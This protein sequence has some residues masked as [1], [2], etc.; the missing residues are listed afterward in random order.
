MP[1]I[2]AVALVLKLA[3]AEGAAPPQMAVDADGS[4]AVAHT[5]T[6]ARGSQETCEAS[7][8]S[9]PRERCN[10]PRI[11]QM[12]ERQFKLEFKDQKPFI[13]SAAENAVFKEQTSRENMERNSLD[14]RPQS[15]PNSTRASLPECRLLCAQACFAMRVAHLHALT[16]FAARVAHP[17]LYVFR[18]LYVRCS[19]AQFWDHGSSYTAGMGALEVGAY[20]RD[21]QPQLANK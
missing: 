7:A 10:I 17:P 15:R 13:M 19:F 9:P 4:A 12:T 14:V 20:V 6:A 2:V 8:A 1:L 21:L 16:C 11:L 3:A 18:V 5:T